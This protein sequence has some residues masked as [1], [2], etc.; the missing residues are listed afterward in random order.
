MYLLSGKKVVFLGLD[1]AFT[2]GKTHHEIAVE[3]EIGEVTIKIP[4]IYGNLVGPAENLNQYRIWIE[5]CIDRARK[6]GCNIEFI[7]A[8]EGGA[9]IQGTE[10]YR[11]C[12]EIK[13]ATENE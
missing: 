7:D 8:T 11:L 1:F 6:D 4:D 9:R 13:E 5:N 3:D 10:I 12:D 2:G